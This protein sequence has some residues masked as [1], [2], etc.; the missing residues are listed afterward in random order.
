MV[1][2]LVKFSFVPE[3][4]MVIQVGKGNVFKLKE[5]EKIK[6]LTKTL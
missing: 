6:T 5:Q 2:K 1:K 4:G 3:E